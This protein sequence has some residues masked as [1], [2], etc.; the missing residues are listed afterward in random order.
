M[1]PPWLDIT[2][3]V[4]SL[5]AIPVLL[6]YPRLQRPV[7]FPPEATETATPGRPVWG[8]TLRIAAAVLLLLPAGLAYGDLGRA[9]EQEPPANPFPYDPRMEGMLHPLPE[10]EMA[11]DFTLPDA[12]TGGRIRL[13]DYRGKKPVLLV[14]GSFGCDRF[15]SQL[16]DLQRLHDKYREELALLLVYITEAPHEIGNLPPKGPQRIAAGLEQYGVSWPCL[17]DGPEGEVEKKYDAYPTRLVL[18]DEQGRLARDL[19]KAMGNSACLE[20]DRW[21]QEHLRGRK[22]KRKD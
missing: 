18:I 10:G 8:K 1:L 14:L 11:P 16:T 17:L 3:I 21:L 12:V 19:G 7:A 6:L 5:A 4:L 9:R 13:S 20:A 15:C 22:E 2:V